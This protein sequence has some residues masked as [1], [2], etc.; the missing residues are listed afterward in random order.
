M[1]RVVFVDGPSTASDRVQRALAGRAEIVVYDGRPTQNELKGRLQGAHTAVIEQAVISESMI[2][3]HRALRHIIVNSTGVNRVVALAAARE[4]GIWVSN[5]PGYSA[6][7]VAEFAFAMLLRLARGLDDAAVSGGSWP[8]KDPGVELGEKALVV[9]GFGPIGQRI[10]WMAARWDLRVLVVNRSPLQPHQLGGSR[11]VSLEEALRQSDLAISCLPAAPGTKALLNKT[12]LSV[13]K[14]GC[15]V[16]SISGPHVFDVPAVIG[17]LDDG[18]IA[19]LAIDR[20]PEEFFPS[21]PRVL[22]TCDLG[23]YTRDAL[24]RNADL[25]SQIIES[26]LRAE[27]IHVVN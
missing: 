5:V 1:H 3:S 4:R 6:R 2:G 20:R 7:S 18:R 19:R 13:L 14:P 12:S 17:A 11:Q 15:L 9:L 27:P 10:A 21:H 23:W 22:Q 8:G 24:G 25:I 16:V 26:G